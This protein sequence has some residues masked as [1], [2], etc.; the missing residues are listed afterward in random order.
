[1]IGRLWYVLEDNAGFL[2]LGVYN[3]ND[4]HTTNLIY[5]HVYGDVLGQLAEDIDN[6]EHGADPLT[7]DNNE[8][9][10]GWNDIYTA[11]LDGLGA[12]L[13]ADGQC[14]IIT[15]QGDTHYYHSRMGVA[16]RMEFGQSIDE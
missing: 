6:L 14:N 13:V 5:Y 2:H 1:M 8:G 4:M 3:Q 16:A 10:D 9:P 15:R 12:T 7:W 11:Y